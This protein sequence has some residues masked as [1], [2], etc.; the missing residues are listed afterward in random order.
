MQ[1]IEEPQKIS[2]SAG[3]S[4][5]ATGTATLGA[6]NISSLINRSSSAATAT[7]TSVVATTTV[8][9]NG[10]ATLTVPGVMASLVGVTAVA[11]V[12]TV[13]LGMMVLGL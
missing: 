9:G 7:D 5:A 10:A 6:G 1:S 3:S 11:S 2:T 12:A 4:T 8:A 13:Y